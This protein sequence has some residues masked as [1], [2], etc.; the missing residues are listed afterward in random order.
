VE[1][2]A[3]DDQVLAGSYAEWRAKGQQSRCQ[4]DHLEDISEISTKTKNSQLLIL[5]LTI[6]LLIVSIMV[7]QCKRSGFR[8]TD[9][10]TI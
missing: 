10:V 9:Q 6:L 8:D 7:P 1:L 2:K 4:P 3:E 5:F